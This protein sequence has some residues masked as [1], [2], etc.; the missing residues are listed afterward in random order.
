MERKGF[1]EEIVRAHSS[2]KLTSAHCQAIFHTKQ[3][4]GFFLDIFEFERLSELV[5]VQALPYEHFLRL[6]RT[7]SLNPVSKKFQFSQHLAPLSED[8][9]GPAF[10]KD[11][12]E[13]EVAK[14]QTFLS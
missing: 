11:A 10:L 14:F 7:E 1:G 5:R 6:A 12:F 13:R 4:R 2:T 9:S 3:R 8:Q